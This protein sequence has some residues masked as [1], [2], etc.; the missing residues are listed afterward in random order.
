MLFDNGNTS[1]RSDGAHMDLFRAPNYHLY[2]S[3]TANKVYSDTFHNSYCV[4]YQTVA[5]QRTFCR[6]N[7]CPSFDPVLIKSFFCFFLYLWQV[8][9]LSCCAMSFLAGRLNAVWM[10]VRNHH[11]HPPFP[12]GL[13]L[14]EPWTEIRINTLHLLHCIFRL[15]LW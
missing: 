8:I 2:L 7:Y 14:F 9:V 11:K 6:K 3:W 5:R 10:S 4:K 1:H 13:Q 12:C 15:W